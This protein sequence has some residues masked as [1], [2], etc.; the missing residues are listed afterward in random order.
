MAVV[1]WKNIYKSNFL[2][3]QDVY[4]LNTNFLWLQNEL[5]SL[6]IPCSGVSKIEYIDDL[7]NIPDA[8]NA[9]EDGMEAINTALLARGIV[10]E[11]FGTKYK[12]R[13]QQR[14]LINKVWRWFDFMWGVKSIITSGIS[15]TGVLYCFDQ[16][17]NTV[18]VYDI[19]GNAIYVEVRIDE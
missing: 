15:D 16:G 3:K 4:D 17:G 12:W 13:Y 9:I 2:T 14:D 7:I 1:A 10:V 5:N 6:A 8:F 18:Q 19:N 11:S